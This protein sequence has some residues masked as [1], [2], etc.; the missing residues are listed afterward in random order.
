MI[1][2]L[3]P[4]FTQLNTPYPATAY[5]VGYLKTLPWP[6]GGLQVRQAD[7]GIETILALFSVAGLSAL[8]EEVDKAV[9]GG[10]V[11][12]D[13]SLRMVRLREDYLA[14]IGPTIRFLQHKNPTL[15][16]AIATR[17]YLPEAN[18]FAELDDLEWAFGTMGLQDK[19][20]HLA[21]LYLEDL[22][23]LI[24]EAIDPHFGFSR[25]AE[26]LGR[27]AAHFDELYQALHQPK[28]LIGK[29]LLQ[30]LDQKMATCNPDGLPPDLVCLSV[31]FPGNL[32]GALLCGQ[33]IKTHY[34]GVRVVMGGGYPNTEL[35]TLA[36]PRLFDFLDFVSLD[37]GEAPLRSL[38]EYLHGDRPIGQLK[39]TFYRNAEGRV[40]FG[41]GAIEKDVAQRDV[42]TPSYADLPLGDYLSV[43]E[44]TNPMH[45]LWSDGRW[46]KLTLAHGCYWGK[47]SFCD[48]SLDYIARYE[49]VTANLLCDRIEVLIAETGQNGFHFVDEAAPPALMR[50][51]ALEILRRRLTVVW[52]TNIRFESAFTADLCQLLKLSGC[53]AVS[54]G[55]EVASDRLL[56]KMKKG[57]TV[58]QVAR[59]AEHFTAA[60]IM[61]HAYLMYGFPTQTTQETIDSLEMVRQLFAAG[62]VQSGFWHRFAMT[63]HSPVGLHPAL[64][65][66]TRI[67]PVGAVDGL[68]PFA[69]NDLD[70]HDPQ[71]ANHDLFAEG[72]RKSLFNFMHGVGLDFP[73]NSWF[74]FTI[75]ATTIPKRFIE[76]AVSEPDDKAP[77]SNALVV[78][79]GRKPDIELVTQ[80]YGKRKTQQAELLLARR[81]DD[82]VV[83]MP[84]GLGEWLVTM[85]PK[86]STQAPAPLTFAQFR[87]DFEQAN[88]GLFTEFLA[89]E[90][91]SDCRE[92]GLLVV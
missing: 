64:F 19:A 15:A 67:D 60:D 39:R 31:P 61:V 57:V 10:T 84:V 7:L 30:L 38:L 12:S 70:H 24:V 52:W 73:L 26:R 34:P 4:P 54:G 66:V 50:D 82:L 11:L 28:T 42:G 55:L 74:D 48:I 5:L 18:R 53:I 80:G 88:L 58:A 43:I 77:R 62:V 6:G 68:G 40:I 79:P 89:S 21:T 1:L 51:L 46:N 27:S 22:S 87:T 47:C 90:T 29:L 20:R 44:V 32:F 56:E 9:L 69:N 33:Y 65:D 86:L 81:Q 35:R 85:W 63:A 17:S 36:E 72:L 14:T 23:D 59:V 78:W 75:P 83:D 37:D 49:P 13:N 2:L 8:F 25:Y 76:R 71:G 92:A 41:N 16:H 3:T 91:W 45:R